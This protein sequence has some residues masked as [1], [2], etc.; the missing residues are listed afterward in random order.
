MSPCARAFATIVAVGLALPMAAHA[1]TASDA[2]SLI[3]LGVQARTERRDSDALA[4]FRRAYDAEHSARGLA[5]IGLAEQALG[6]WVDA[7]KHLVAA[8]A[9]ENDAWI[10]KRRGALTSA[11]EVVQSKLASIEV[12]CEEANAELFLNGNAV[13]PLPLP[14]QRVP[15][16]TVVVELRAEGFNPLH[17][18]LA[19]ESRQSVLLEPH[20]SPVVGG[21]QTPVVGNAVLPA[22]VQPAHGD[23][24]RSVS[25]RPWARTAAWTA[26]GLGVTFLAEAVTMHVA[27]EVGVAHYNDDSRCFYGTLSREQRC[28]SV[29]GQADV[30]GTL[31]IVGYSAAAAAFATS[32]LLFVMVRP[33]A[34]PSATGPH[35][36]L[37]LVGHGS[38]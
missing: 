38:F 3:E 6:N 11:L 9:T 5:Q 22:T 12:R 30:E 35:L 26:F 20:L 10:E 13:G 21:G 8:I 2:E 32:G 19:L 34:D 1:Q 33:A 23:S 18:A 4:L 7:E 29:L 28:G 31:A 15:A 14:P 27:R 36:G 24:V 16:G 25:P 37:E 17:E